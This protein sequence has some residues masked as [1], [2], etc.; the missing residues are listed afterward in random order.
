M[1]WITMVWEEI[2]KKF[3]SSLISFSIFV[4]NCYIGIVILIETIFHI[5]PFF[6]SIKYCTRTVLPKG[7]GYR[8]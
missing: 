7:A 2:L 6:C 4:N 8:R 3:I 5:P 1:V